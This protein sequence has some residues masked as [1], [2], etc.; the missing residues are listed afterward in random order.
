MD[1]WDTICVKNISLSFSNTKMLHRYGC[2][3]TLVGSRFLSDTE[4]QVVGQILGSAWSTEQTKD[5]T[6]VCDKLIVVTDHKPFVELLGDRILD[7]I[8]KMCLFR[9]KER[10]L[11]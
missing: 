1:D 8:T 3:I 6:H 9:L 10:T 2:K 5:F 4:K 7:K 11:V